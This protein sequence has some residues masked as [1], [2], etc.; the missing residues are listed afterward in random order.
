MKAKSYAKVNIFLKIVGTR[1]DYH[2]LIS[3]FV[4][5]KNLYDIVSFEEKETK[6]FEL[7][8]DFGCDTKENTIYKAYKLLCDLDKRVEI[9]FRSH[10]VTVQKQIPSFAGLGGGSSNA[11]VFITMA[12]DAIGLGLSKKQMAE[13]GKRVGADVPFFIHGYNSANV[14]GI[15][16]IVEPFEEET[17]EFDIITP[18]IKC[19]TKEIYAVFRKRFLKHTDIA[20]AKKL[21]S[22][23]SKY[24]MENYEATEVN[25]LLKAA[26]VVKPELKEYLQ[27][28]WFMSG[29]GSSFFRLKYMK[30]KHKNESHSKK[31]KSFSRF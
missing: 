17:L 2:E 14:S 27:P 11:A 23:K 5:V 25:D 13:L 16:E 18:R 3:R 19:D 22:M 29:S 20:F 26:L 9:F 15:G 28:G 1:G 21:A 8:G 31:Q 4:L 24:I 7:E 6:G 12:N 10:K 30:E